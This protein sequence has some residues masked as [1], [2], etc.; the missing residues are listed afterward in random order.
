MPLSKA[1]LLDWI[2]RHSEEF[3]DIVCELLRESKDGN[4]QISVAVEKYIKLV[5]TLDRKMPI[6]KTGGSDAAE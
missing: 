2:S 4:E 5:G 1:E 3:R 6:S